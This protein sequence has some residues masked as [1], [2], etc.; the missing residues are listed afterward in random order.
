[1]FPVYPL[2]L[3][4]GP[5]PLSLARPFRPGPS[6]FYEEKAMSNQ[7]PHQDGASDPASRKGPDKVTFLILGVLVAAVVGL[8]RASRRRGARSSVSRRAGVVRWTLVA[9]GSSPR[10]QESRDPVWAIM[11][12]QP[13]IPPWSPSASSHS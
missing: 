11:A 6:S 7:N 3:I 5:G 10:G 13:M 12:A 8:V 9:A 1:M 4:V 2:D